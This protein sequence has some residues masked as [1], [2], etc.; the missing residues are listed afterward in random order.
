MAQVLSPLNYEIFS[1]NCL[2]H[3]CVVGVPTPLRD[4]TSKPHKWAVAHDDSDLM[5]LPVNVHHFLKTSQY[6]WE[7]FCKSENG[8]GWHF[9][10]S[11]RQSKYHD[12]GFSQTTPTTGGRKEGGRKTSWGDPHGQEMSPTLTSIRFAPN[13]ISC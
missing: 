9:L 10:S 2:P 11:Q 4:S 7:A 6:G 3:D 12:E 8:V 1:G 13:Y 5:D